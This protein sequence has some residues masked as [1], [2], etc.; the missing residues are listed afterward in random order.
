MKIKEIQA[1][2]LCMFL[3]QFLTEKTY[4]KTSDYKYAVIIYTVRFK[5]C[6][7]DFIIVVNTYRLSLVLLIRFEMNAF[8]QFASS[9]NHW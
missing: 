9:L 3:R 7:K 1:L 2:K 4:T 8:P 5:C 6:L